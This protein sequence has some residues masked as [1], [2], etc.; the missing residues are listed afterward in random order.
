M[1]QREFGSGRPS[2][3]TG[4]VRNDVDA[5]IANITT[6]NQSRRRSP[7]GIETSETASRSALSGTTS[8]VFDMDHHLLNLLPGPR[9]GRWGVAPQCGALRGRRLIPVRRTLRH[10]QD[11]GGALLC[12]I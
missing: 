4:S 6:K 2:R 7:S 10:P 9:L 8:A 12:G 5:K 11:L 1:N 3:V